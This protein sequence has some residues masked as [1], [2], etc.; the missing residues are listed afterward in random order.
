MVKISVFEKEPD[1]DGIDKQVSEIPRAVIAYY[2]EYVDSMFD[3]RIFEASKLQVESDNVPAWAFGCFVGWLYTHRVCFDL[4]GVESAAILENGTK[5]P[6]AAEDDAGRKVNDEDDKT[7]V[8]IHRRQKPATPTL[9]SASVPTS[10]ACL[11]IAGRHNL[12]TDFHKPLTWIW[13]T[14][15]EIYICADY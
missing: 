8:E 13:P 10:T 2:S 12:T 15:L 3:D 11:Q 1:P 4:P 9:T 6:K 14:L 7:S 5:A